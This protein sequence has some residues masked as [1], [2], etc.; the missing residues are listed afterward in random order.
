MT[1]EKAGRISSAG[2]GSADMK[3]TGIVRQLDELGRIVLPKEMRRTLG[4]EER[5][6]LEI[7]ADGNT[8]VLRKFRVGCVFCGSGKQVQ[9]FVYQKG[10]GGL[11]LASEG[12]GVPVCRS[13]AM[14]AAERMGQT[15]A[16]PDEEKDRYGS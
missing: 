13:C 14:A 7:W 10:A 11:M 9:R 15:P 6:P 5:D 1:K 4:I 16:A 2:K 8:I 12:E 3:N